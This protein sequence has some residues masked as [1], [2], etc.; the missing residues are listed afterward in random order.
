M[1]K[2]KVIA[3]NINLLFCQKCINSYKFLKHERTFNR[4]IKI[5]KSKFKFKFKKSI[6]HRAQKVFRI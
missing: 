2:S 4:I 1:D 6:D 3:A 5:L